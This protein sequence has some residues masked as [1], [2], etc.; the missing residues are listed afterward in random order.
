MKDRGIGS[1]PDNKIG[2]LSGSLLDI[3]FGFE[4]PMDSTD[5]RAFTASARKI[6]EDRNLSK[7]DR[8]KIFNESYY[9]VP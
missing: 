6:V 4:V 2:P 7:T 5:G 9:Q 8:Q 1:S 3:L